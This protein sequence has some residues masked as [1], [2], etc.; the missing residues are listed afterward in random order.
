MGSLLFLFFLITILEGF[1]EVLEVNILVS[2]VM[3]S[4]KSLITFLLCFSSWNC[5]KFVK[6]VQ[7]CFFK[8]W[9]LEAILN[10]RFSV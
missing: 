1:Q 3:L 10:V 4:W 7:L 2:S 9:M 8:T 6:R 5:F